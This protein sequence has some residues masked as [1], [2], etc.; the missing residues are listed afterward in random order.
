MQELIR[1]ELNGKRTELL[2]DPA[3][4]LLWVLRYKCRLTGTKYGCG[5]GFCGACTILMDEDPVRSCMM[6]V[7][8]ALEKKIITIEGLSANGNS[9]PVQKATISVTHDSSPDSGSLTKNK[10]KNQHNY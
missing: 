6:P 7:S 3:Q 4:T 1:F 2:V 9:H 5:S 10:V 8:D